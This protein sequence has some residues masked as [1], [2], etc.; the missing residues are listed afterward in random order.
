MKVEEIDLSSI[1]SLQTPVNS[2]LLKSC[3]AQA[4]SCLNKG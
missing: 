1:Q 4:V 2:V 3:S